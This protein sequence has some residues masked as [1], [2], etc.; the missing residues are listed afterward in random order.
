MQIINKTVQCTECGCIAFPDA[1]YCPKCGASYREN[2]AKKEITE[3]FEKISCFSTPD[4]AD[5]SKS[6]IETYCQLTCP[7][8]GQVDIKTAVVIPTIKCPLCQGN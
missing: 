1:A 7:H 4:S 6:I 2:K 8:H 3:I 5:A